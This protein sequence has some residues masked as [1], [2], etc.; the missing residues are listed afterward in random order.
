MNDAVKNGSMIRS[1]LWIDGVAGGSTA[2]V[3]LLFCSPLATLL[4]LPQSL[5]LIIAFVTLLY[6]GVALTLVIRSRLSVALLRMLINA[7]WFWTLISVGLLA[8]YSRTA[9]PLG[10]LFLVLQ[11]VVVGGLAYAEGHQLRRWKRLP[12]PTMLSN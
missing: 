7:N 3:G 11:V 8:G 1:T 4:G 5:I 10:I 12:D 9:T 2:L 6:A